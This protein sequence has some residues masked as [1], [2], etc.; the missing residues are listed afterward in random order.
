LPKN[1]QNWPINTQT[2]TRITTPHLAKTLPGMPINPITN[3]NHTRPTLLRLAD[4]THSAYSQQER[5]NRK[6][7]RF[8]R[9]LLTE[10]I[11]RPNK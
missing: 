5:E 11:Q 1:L 9:W 7:S 4:A 10:K 2:E 3:S 8:S 6:T